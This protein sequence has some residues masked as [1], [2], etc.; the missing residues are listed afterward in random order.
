MRLAATGQRRVQAGNA[1]R[2]TLIEPGSEFLATADPQAAE[3]EGFE[4]VV[5]MRAQPGEAFQYLEVEIGRRANEKADRHILAAAILF[6]LDETMAEPLETLER[7]GGA[8]A[9]LR[10]QAIAAD[11]SARR[12][13]A[14]LERGGSISAASP[15]AMHVNNPRRS[16]LCIILSSRLA[17]ALR[18]RI[19]RVRL[20][21]RRKECTSLG[22]RPSRPLPP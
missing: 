13:S 8:F 16:I 14:A 10:D 7:Q 11:M 15:A 5:A 2:A 20:G 3:I 6:P 19:S 4:H 9:R 12:E 22:D 1:G 17:T 18:N 21:L